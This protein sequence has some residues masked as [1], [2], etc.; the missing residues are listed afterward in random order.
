VLINSVQGR[1][2]FF[3]RTIGLSGLANSNVLSEFFRK[4][5]TLL[6]QPNLG[7]KKQNCNNYSITSVLRKNVLR[8][9]CS[10][11]MFG[12]LNL[13]PDKVKGVLPWQLNFEKNCTD[14]RHTEKYKNL[15]FI[16]VMLLMLK[17]QQKSM[18][19]TSHFKT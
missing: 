7:R 1:E 15:I 3:A 10:E 18:E 6:W 13:L 2:T 5:M 9:S 19:K 14:C 12:S 4:Q 16:T 11:D 8:N 17:K